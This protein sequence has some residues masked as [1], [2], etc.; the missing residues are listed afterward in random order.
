MHTRLEDKLQELVLSFYHVGPGN[1][2]Q[3][4]GLWWQVSLPVELSDGLFLL[5]LVCH[6]CQQ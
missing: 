2:M 6:S 5:S 1:Q 3:V 4:F